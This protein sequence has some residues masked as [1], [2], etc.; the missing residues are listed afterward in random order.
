MSVQRFLRRVAVVSIRIVILVSLAVLLVYL[1]NNETEQHNRSKQHGSP[2]SS[3]IT[4]YSDARRVFWRELYPKQFSTLY[5]DEEYANMPSRGVNIEHVFPMAW[6]TKSIDCGTRKQCRSN[7]LF[8][9]IE[10]DLHNLYPSRSDINKARGSLRFANIMGETREFGA[11]CDFEVS[12]RQ[13]AVEPRPEVRGDIARAMFYMVDR[14]PKA[15]LEI[16]SKQKALLKAWHRADP[17][18][19]NERRRNDL[20]ERLQGNR[21]PFIDTPEKL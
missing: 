2:A 15:K 7:A 9:L 18:S 17:P 20:I 14:Y 8:N 5:C 4:N 11:Y 10:S 16:F 13:R 12:K 19:A 6:A 1:S 3:K 21:N